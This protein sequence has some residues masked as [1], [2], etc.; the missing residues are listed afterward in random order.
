[1][2]DSVVLPRRR[3]ILALDGG[4]VRGVFSLAIL[5]R[6]EALLREQTGKP[7]AVLA[8][9][10]D[11]VAG[12]STGAII[13]SFLSWGEEVARIQQLYFEQAAAMFVR[14]P[15][16]RLRSGG[17]YDATGLRSFLRDYFVEEDGSPALL[18]TGK[19]RTLL[20]LV[21][22]NATT[23]SAWPVTNNPRAMFNDPALPDCNL[24]LPLW[25]LVRASAAA[26]LYFPAETPRYRNRSCRPSCPCRLLRG[27][28]LG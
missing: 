8:D 2:P 27:Y 19:L 6:M 26:P 16:W 12:T 28:G 10:F 14:A 23:G 1:M 25:Q 15:L 21:M 3:R 7:S 9:H 17:L 18:G 11:F 20:M 22:R 5:A 13:A 24:R 4:G